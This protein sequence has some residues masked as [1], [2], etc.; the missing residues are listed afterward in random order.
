MRKTIFILLLFS[1]LLA[2]GGCE[3]RTDQ[4]EGGVVLSVSDFDG[5]PLQISVNAQGNAP[6]QVD[7]LTLQNLPANPN[8]TTSPL[9]NIEL[10]SYEVV[11]TRT[12]NGTRVP[13]PLVASIFGVVPINGTADY[14]NLAVMS[15]EQ[16]SAPPLSDL[17]F[18]NGGFDT[19]TGNR[20]VRLNLQ[21]RFFGRTLTGNEVVTAPSRFDIV[22]VP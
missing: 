20:S 13:A 19:E 17:L 12:D 6:V 1:V 9:M 4:S 16:F 3:S 18:A 5:L 14:V 7:Q 15:G 10:R 21:L 2:V 8:L 11:Y 22:F